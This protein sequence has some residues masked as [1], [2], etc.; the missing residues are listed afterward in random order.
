MVQKGRHDLFENGCWVAIHNYTLNHPLDYPDD[1]VNQNGQPL[2]Q[3][4]YDELAAWAYSHLT[5]DQIVAQGIPISAED[6]AKFNRWAWDGRPMEMVNE[7]RAAQQEPGR[8]R[9]STT[10][11]ASAATRR[12]AR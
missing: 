11:T 12:P 8:R 5:Y 1:P 2:T 4:E 6:Y 9:S 7:I 10:P 3:E